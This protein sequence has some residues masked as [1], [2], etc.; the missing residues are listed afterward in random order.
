MDSDLVRDY[1]AD[2]ESASTHLVADARAEL[3]GDVRAHIGLALEEAGATDDATV[4]GV[5]DRLGPPSAIVTGDAADSNDAPEVV[6]SAPEHH[7]VTPRQLS[8]E[9]RALLL[10]TVGAVALPFLGPLLGLWFASGS[11]R[12]TLT[13]KRTVA[14]ILLVLLAMPAAL[15]VPA[16]LAGEITWVFTSGGFLLPFVPL[17]GWLAASYLIVSSSLVLKVSRRT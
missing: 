13:Q 6:R 7:V 5:L 11:T 4:R 9:T 17:A 8:V 10:F 12:W 16:A 1:L 3:L 14:L 15:L 2:L